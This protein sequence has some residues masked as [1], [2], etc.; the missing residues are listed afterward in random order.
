MPFNVS[1]SS[2]KFREAY[3][4][5]P[6]TSVLT[7]NGAMDFLK[8]LK[9]GSKDKERKD[10]ILSACPEHASN[11]LEVY[12]DLNLVTLEFENKVDSVLT[13]NEKEY[14][15]IYG[16]HAGQLDQQLC[17]LQ[18]TIDTTDKG[19]ARASH[20]EHLR[21]EIKWFSDEAV[22]LSALCK[23]H[24]ASLLKWRSLTES[25]EEEKMFL[26]RILS[27]NRRN[28]EALTAQCRS[29]V[30]E[31]D[32]ALTAPEAAVL[33]DVAYP[34][35]VSPEDVA[36]MNQDFA[37]MQMVEAEIIKTKKAI[38]ELRNCQS[39]PNPIF[40]KFKEIVESSRN[41]RISKTEKIQI[42]EKLL[43]DPEVLES[44]V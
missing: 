5:P 11:L 39:A 7:S 10:L 19:A 24:K 26:E 18:A 6:S 28:L 15:A 17:T 43:L 12:K 40:S 42:L 33:E 22:R 1:A 30:Q 9:L 35:D 32:R 25:Y 21:S 14:L 36:S 31:S 27:K 20:I 8:N 23:S 13:S 2:F 44:L 41:G 29:L 3:D 38:D 37:N 4:L 16:N 34:I